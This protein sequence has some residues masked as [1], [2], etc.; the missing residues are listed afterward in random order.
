[1]I[2]L[3]LRRRNRTVADDLLRS[4]A[5]YGTKR[6]EDG[7]LIWKR[8]P[9]LAKGFVETAVALRPPDLLPNHLHFWRRQRD[10]ASRDPGPS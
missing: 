2:R 1:M 7:R 5:H 10:R 4:Y 3:C 8:D 9:A 6:R